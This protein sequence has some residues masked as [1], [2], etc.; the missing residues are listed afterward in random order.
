M[1]Y[2]A[3]I[4]A[5]F[6][7]PVFHR[8]RLH[9]QS[10]PIRDVA[11]AVE[12]AMAAA[13]ET[14]AIGPGETVAV[15][16]GSR[17]ITGL[18]EMVGAV[19]GHLKAIGARP[20]IL[21]AMGSHGGA[22]EEGQA[23]VLAA[24]GVT[25]SSCGAPVHAGMAVRRIGTAMGEM[26]VWFSEAALAADHAICI[27]RI[28]P[29]TKFKAPAESGIFKMLCIGM[30]KHDGALAFH[31]YALKHGFFPLLEAVGDVVVRK[32]NFRFG[33]GVVEDGQDQPAHIEAL[34][35]P[36]IVRREQVLL[37]MAEAHLPRLPAKTADVLVI[38][39]I[40][41]EISGAG[42]DPNITGRAY[43]FMESDFSGM[44]HATRVAILNLS[45]ASKGNAIGLGNAD[46]ITE[47]VWQAMDYE[48][49]VMNALTGVSLRKAAIPVRLPTD[50]KAIQACFT[51][52]GP[53]PPGAVRAILI[54]D[55][56]HLGEIWVSTAMKE[57]I[58]R[59]P[60]AEV[61]EPAPLPF[62]EAGN[63]TLFG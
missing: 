32:S 62:D 49:T 22:T 9:H 35:P 43:D 7:F 11:A 40:G 30:G 21:P 10:D 50:R 31:R 25:E 6:P 3:Y 17:G 29:H 42:M 8:V 52:I 57:E 36:E 60:E 44:F 20:V 4:E 41:K 34:L 63:L 45:E 39:K 28:K 55:T 48:A 56:R 37:K 14:S 54:R 26:P 38:G 47:K 51:T 18:P 46:I 24:L 23:A 16:V 58:A 61:G 5:D 2:P 59:V 1:R 27:N 33:I 15:G 13:L 19:C 12:T 53:V